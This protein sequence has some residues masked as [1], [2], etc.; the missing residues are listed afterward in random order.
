MA[1]L[2]LSTGI[3]KEALIADT[4][5]ALG[6]SG[7]ITRSKIAERQQRDARQELSLEFFFCALASAE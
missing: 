5:P 1:K 6:V 4:A 2:L 7:Q 3:C